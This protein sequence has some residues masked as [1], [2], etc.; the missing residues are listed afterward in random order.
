MPRMFT[1]AHNS[2]TPPECQTEIE[3][4]ECGG[5]TRLQSVGPMCESAIIGFCALTN[6]TTETDGTEFD[7]WEK[8]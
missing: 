2:E 7:K 8:A 6:A 3:C 4:F 5:L 1:F